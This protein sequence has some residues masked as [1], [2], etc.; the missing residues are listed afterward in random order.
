MSKN[1]LIVE[2]ARTVA[3]TPFLVVV[4]FIAGLRAAN[5]QAPAG[6]ITAISGT[7]NITRGTASIPAAFNTVVDVGDRIVTGANGRATITLRDSTQIEVTESSTLVLTE[8]L[9]NPDG[10]RA[11]TKVTVLGGLIHSLVRFTAGTPPNFEVH[12]PNAIASARGTTY[13]TDYQNGTAREG[14]KDCT[15]FTDVSVYDGTVEVSNPTN[16][17]AP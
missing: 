16:P 6:T 17:S 1:R 3:L 12:T 7:V 14:Y 4:G 5:A 10:T 2:A 11:S 8:N 15:E 13:D 9:L